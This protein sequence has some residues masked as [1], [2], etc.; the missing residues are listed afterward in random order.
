MNEI[1]ELKGNTIKY[2][3]FAKKG[4]YSVSCTV[5]GNNGENEYKIIIPLDFK[6]LKKILNI[7]LIT[8]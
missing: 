5:V 4:K 7:I 3:K 8:I 1:F 6:N 2:K